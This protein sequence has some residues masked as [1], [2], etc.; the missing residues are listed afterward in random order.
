MIFN[1]FKKK[2]KTIQLKDLYGNS[3]SVGDRVESL[4]YDLGICTLIDTEKGFEYESE[5]SGQKVSYAK[6]IDAAT[7]LQKV[8]KIS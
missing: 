3:L 6:M 7:T 5:S 1:L 2:K 4:R 8:K